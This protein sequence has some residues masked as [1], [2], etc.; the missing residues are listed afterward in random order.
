[1]TDWV[2][3]CTHFGHANIIRLCNRP[4]ASV[5]EMDRAMIENWNRTVGLRDSYAKAAG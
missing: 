5:E 3:G 1:M 2:I 4:F